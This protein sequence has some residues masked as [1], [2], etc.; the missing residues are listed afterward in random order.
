MTAFA[1]TPALMLALA[2]LALVAANIYYARR[3]AAA[4]AAYAE[5]GR[6]SAL[7]LGKRGRARLAVPALVAVAILLGTIAAARPVGPPDAQDK[8]E[9]GMDVVVALDVSAS[10]AVID[11]LPDRLES[12]KNR[13]AE[14]MAAAPDNRYGLVLFSGEATVSCPLTADHDAL[15]TFLDGAGFDSVGLPGTALGEAVLTAAT[16]FK[17]GEL[18]RAVL[19]ISDGG[20]TYGAEPVEAASSAMA[21]GMK[22]YALGVGGTAGG[23]IPV[24]KDFFGETIY[25]RDRQGR[26][27]NSALDMRSLETMAEAG[28]GKAFS[29]ATPGAV[30]ALARELT[31]RTHKQVKGVPAN[32]KEYGQYFALAAFALLAAA[33]VL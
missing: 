19:V 33:L 28:G 17:P 11:E 6:L 3:D 25:K 10:M 7:G 27:V 23:R 26:M 5:T 1:N 18:P 2:A 12:A 9:A 14:L 32:A 21:K 30:D 4:R 13:V 22:V 8:G 29:A 15:L 16:R 20:N 31:T 24:G